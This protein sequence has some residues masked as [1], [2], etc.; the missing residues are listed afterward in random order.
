MEGGVIPTLSDSRTIGDTPS[1]EEVESVEGSG[2]GE[3]GSL[4]VEVTEST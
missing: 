1:R 2:H 4:D 3:L